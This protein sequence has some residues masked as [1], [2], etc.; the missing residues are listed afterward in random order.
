VPES[1]TA[2]GL[3]LAVSVKVRLATRVPAASGLN[4]TL[5]EQLAET[6]RLV[7]QVLLEIVKSAEF[8][9][10]TE[11]LLSEMEAPLSFFKEVDN[12][13]L[14]EPTFTAPNERA[15]GVALAPDVPVPDSVTVCG[16]PL[17]VSLK[18]RVAVRLP[19]VVGA[20]T[21]LTVQ[22]AD[23]PKLVPQVFVKI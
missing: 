4:T 8:V 22:L 20:K 5:T 7:P 9:P 1:A 12:A 23:A 18:L 21:I 17:P 2:C 10:V 3:L 19:V 13:A 6:A 16:L 15:D 14:L 11:M